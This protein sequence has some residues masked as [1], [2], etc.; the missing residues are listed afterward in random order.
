[1]E[2]LYGFTRSRNF[3]LFRLLLQ[4]LNH[5]AKLYYLTHMSQICL[6]TQVFGKPYQLSV[7]IFLGLV[8]VP[9]SGTTG[10]TSPPAICAR[11]NLALVEIG[12]CRSNK[13]DKKGLENCTG[14]SS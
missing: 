5:C 6:A 3:L 9:M 10:T 13:I 7:I 4:C 1:M 2:F 14:V 12:Q 11:L 8:F